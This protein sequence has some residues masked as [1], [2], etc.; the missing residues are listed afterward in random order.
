[1]GQKKNDKKA[2]AEMSPTPYRSNKRLMEDDGVFAI[3]DRMKSKKIKDSRIVKSIAIASAGFVGLTFFST[4]VTSTKI[5]NFSEQVQAVESSAFKTRYESLGE[6]IIGSYYGGRDTPINLL[7]GADWPGVNENGEEDS[8]SS[9]TSGPNGGAS[10]RVNDVALMDGYDSVVSLN[11]ADADLDVSGVF[12][13]PRKETLFYTANI[14]GNKEVV[15]L[16]ILI[17]DIND[18]AKEPYLIT[19]PS[20]ESRHSTVESGISGSEPN[21]GDFFEEV[22]LNEYSIDTI[23]DWASAM[24]SND[25]GQLKRIAGDN[26]G[27]HSYRGI[28]G[29]ELTD[30]PQIQWSYEYE[31]NGENYIVARVRY[32]ITTDAQNSSSSSADSVT[33]NSDSDSFMPTQTMDVL[34]ANY[35]E[36]AP[37][38][39][40]W[41]GGGSWDTLTPGMNAIENDVE[42]SIEEDS[43]DTD[44][45]SSETSSS[46]TGDSDSDNDI[47]GA[48]EISS[49]DLESNSSSS[50][51]S[52]SNTSSSGTSGSSRSSTSRSSSSSSN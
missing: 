52:S 14:N 37:N 12:S 26:N 27:N 47:P 39:V 2:M 10:A 16:Q 45:D 8:S 29:Y 25:S 4:I 32:V 13:D 46:T 30:S 48:P 6:V 33:G 38:I 11:E 21:V 41:G 5:S 31:E 1:M 50:S 22:T 35:S 20:I 24:A 23:T 51:S 3:M 34:L 49:D 7:A 17:P 9:G 15:S 42:G 19:P 43:D 40:A 44:S 28:G 36:G 18:T